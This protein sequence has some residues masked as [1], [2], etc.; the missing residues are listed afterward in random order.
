MPQRSDR[1]TLTSTILL[2][3]SST[4]ARAIA[5]ALM[6]MIAVI[7]V[8]A[9]GQPGMA[10]GGGQ[11]CSGPGCDDQIACGQP[12]QP[13]ATS[14]PSASISPVAVTVSVA[15][16][17]IDAHDGTLTAPPILSSSASQSFA[18][19]APRSPPSA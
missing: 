14:G 13:Q 16:A 19:S 12:I 6:M 10:F 3:E 17:L 5:I 7:G 15:P 11:D 9:L 18:P 2:K 1:D 4:G 8:G